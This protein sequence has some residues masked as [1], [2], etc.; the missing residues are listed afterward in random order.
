M[1]PECTARARLQ[2]IRLVLPI[3]APAIWSALGDRVRRVGQRLRGGRHAGLQ[4][5]LLPRPPTSCTRRSTTS[6]RASRPPPAMGWLLVASVAIPLALPGAGAARPLL[7]GAVRPYPAGQSRAQLERAGKVA[8]VSGVG[9]FF[10][11]ALGVPGFGAISA[12]LLGGLRR[13]LLT[14]AVEL[15]GAVRIDAGLTG[16]LERSLVYGAITASITVVGGFIAARLLCARTQRRST[17]APGLPAAR[18][19]GAAQRGVRRR[20]HL[21]LQ[22]AVLVPAR[23]QP[24]PDGRRC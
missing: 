12:S 2:A 1:P 21:R 6:R 10:L 18:R 24:V 4:L 22:P 14:H 19:R 5:E 23:H 15:P 7:R 20:L 3:L 13:L 16:P 8:A 17:T 9:L 11:V